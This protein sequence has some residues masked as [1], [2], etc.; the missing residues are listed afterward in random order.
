MSSLTI[1][2][3]AKGVWPL[4]LKF[5][6]A[7]VYKCKYNSNEAQMLFKYS[8][9][10]DQ[11][12]TEIKR[13]TPFSPILI[14]LPKPKLYSKFNIFESED[15]SQDYSTL[16]IDASEFRYTSSPENDLEWVQ[17]DITDE[18]MQFFIKRK[19]RRYFSELVLLSDNFYYRIEMFDPPNWVFK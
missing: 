11:V 2:E 12:I 1:N 7:N 5:C 19:N 8:L 3:I 18:G 14:E 4:F 6:A 16:F 17:T 9:D 13:Q 15:D 10:D